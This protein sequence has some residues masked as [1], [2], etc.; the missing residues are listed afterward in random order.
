MADAAERVRQNGRVIRFSTTE[1]GVSKFFLSPSGT[2]DIDSHSRACRYSNGEYSP[3]GIIRALDNG[4]G[5]QFF[6]QFFLNGTNN[7]VY[8]LQVGDDRFLGFQHREPIQ[9][10]CNGVFNKYIATDAK[11]L[12]DRPEA[13]DVVCLARGQYFVATDKR[14][15]GLSRKLTL[16]PDKIFPP[17]ED[18]PAS[19]YTLVI[20]PRVK[21]ARYE[22]RVRPY[23]SNAEALKAMSKTS[24]K[25]DW[26]RSF[27]DYSS[28]D[29]PFICNAIRMGE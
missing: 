23:L 27:F 29:V 12:R 18:P 7:P 17:R 19:F 16:I 24:G 1:N 10:H 3:F 21:K 22:N 2:I 26:E 9:L 5:R 11:P 13:G 25:Q 20:C 14:L 28:G 6:L 8:F 4:S 15:K